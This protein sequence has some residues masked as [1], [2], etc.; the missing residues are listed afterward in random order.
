MFVKGVGSS[1]WWYAHRSRR[2]GSHGLEAPCMFWLRLDD[3]EDARSVVPAQHQTT[4]GSQLHHAAKRGTSV[5]NHETSTFSSPWPSR[6]PQHQHEQCILKMDICPRPK[7]S[8]RTMRLFSSRQYTEARDETN[9]N[10][11]PRSS[12]FL[13]VSVSW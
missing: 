7:T 3:I 8:Q 13:R 10:H 6:K 12:S 5:Q 11:R 2:C 4:W 9:P 1:P